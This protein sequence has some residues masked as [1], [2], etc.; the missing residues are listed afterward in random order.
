VVSFS[1]VPL[2]SENKI[3][4]DLFNK[5]LKEGAVVMVYMGVEMVAPLLGAS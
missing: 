1:D 3:T 2:K 5:A 4:A